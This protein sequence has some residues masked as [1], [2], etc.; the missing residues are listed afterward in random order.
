MKIVVNLVN[1]PGEDG[2]GERPDRQEV[3]MAIA[4]VMSYRG[5]CGRAQVGCVIVA[6]D[7]RI[8]SSGYNG[9]L[10]G[11]KHC[12]EHMCNTKEKCQHSVHA[13]ANAIAFA[14]R[15]G[16]SLSGSTLYCTTAPCKTCAQ[17][18]I[19]A[20]IMRV[21]FEKVYSTDNGSG[22]DLLREQNIKV[23]RHE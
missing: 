17:L 11:D 19:Q 13:E 12:D 15:A 20:G 5:T 8:I 23:W 22:V 21:V 3:F 7:H 14:A 1:E 2:V 10:L 9:T 6:P 16:I 18:I 4:K